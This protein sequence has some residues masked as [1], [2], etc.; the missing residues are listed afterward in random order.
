[1]KQV[2]FYIKLLLLFA[3]LAL[4]VRADWQ[5]KKTGLRLRPL[6]SELIEVLPDTD[7]T[8]FRE[9]PIPHY[10]GLI[11]SDESG[12]QEKISR[13]AAALQTAQIEP[14]FKGFVDEINTLICLD[15]TGMICGAKIISHRETPYY[16]KIIQDSQ[17]LDNILKR[18]I[19]DGLED[20]DAVT[21]ATITSEAIIADIR[22]AALSAGRDLYGLELEAPPTPSLRGA[23]A[24]PEFLILVLALALGLCA[25]Y[26]RFPSWRREAVYVF[27]ILTIGFYLNTPFSLVHV[28]Q[29]ASLKWPGTSNP[30]LL[31]LGIFVLATTIFTGPVY[32]GYVCPFGAIQDLL[33]RVSPKAW[34]WQVSTRL[35]RVA[36]E[37]RY[38]VL[39]ACVLG[40]FGIG[41]KAFSEIEPFSHL[42][43]I[44]RSIAPWLLIIL[45]LFL[46]LFVRRFWCRFFCPTGAC[47]VMLS[48]HRRFFRHIETGL[49]SSEIDP[50][51]TVKQEEA[52]DKRVC[53]INGDYP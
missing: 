34:H 8:A 7:L 39:F 1:M 47:L 17:F 26:F 25:R 14:R 52:T 38:L 23:L 19:K 12:E 13:R 24:R 22:A 45:V 4:I 43:A 36:R 42:F 44:T 31:I 16:M 48:A 29:L 10:P 35:L 20:I 33:Y 30:G 27:S 3:G 15:E 51:A 2:W 28:F 53:D 21:G 41:I 40:F 11:T 50:A 5:A 46:S 6:S 18:N 32:C 37:M 49:K 9:K